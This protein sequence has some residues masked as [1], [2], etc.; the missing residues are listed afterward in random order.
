MKNST[1][2]PTNIAYIN[3]STKEVI[4]GYIYYKDLYL[5]SESEPEVPIYNTPQDYF[6]SY[7]IHVD[8]LMI[9]PDVQ[10]E[11][12][13]KAIVCD[14]D[15]VLNTYKKE[16]GVLLK[17]GTHEPNWTQ[18]SK[19]N[20][21]EPVKFMFE[22][23]ISFLRSHGRDSLIIFMTARG[24]TQRY[25]T[26]KFLEENMG[27]WYSRTLLFM[28]GQGCNRKSAEQIKVERMAGA[29]L[30]YF[31][32]EAFIDDTVEVIKAINNFFPHITTMTVNPKA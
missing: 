28:R 16:K 9:M 13:P 27:E 15:G 19:M 20:E 32:V 24:E 25:L 17:D 8:D 7:S 18:F 22:M 6:P 29:V 23:L 10:Y 2:K 31:D 12:K 1:I 4:K 3:W 5:V 11:N 30:P 26:E 14:I 21:V